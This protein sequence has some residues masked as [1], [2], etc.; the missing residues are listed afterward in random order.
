LTVLCP[1][2]PGEHRQG[3]RRQATYE[4]STSVDPSTGSGYGCDAT[5]GT[6]VESSGIQLYTDG[7][8]RATPQ[9]SPLSSSIPPGSSFDCPSLRFGVPSENDDWTAASS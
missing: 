2:A 6:T 9:N 7:W 3:E 4:V 1:V 5:H 8:T